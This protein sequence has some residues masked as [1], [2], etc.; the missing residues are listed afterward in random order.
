M[1]TPASIFAALKTRR[2]TSL[3]SSARF[4]MYCSDHPFGQDVPRFAAFTAPGNAGNQRTALN[5]PDRLVVNTTKRIQMSHH[6]DQANEKRYLHSHCRIGAHR[7]ISWSY[8]FV[9]RL[10]RQSL[11]LPTH[12]HPRRRPCTL[13]PVVSGRSPP[14]SGG[15]PAS[16]GR[17]RTPSTPRCSHRHSQAGRRRSHFSRHSRAPVIT[18]R[19]APR[20]TSLSGEVDVI[21]WDR[22]LLGVPNKSGP[23]E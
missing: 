17:R 4:N 7:R 19:P 23:G 2:M 15:R 22:S 9:R 18:G 13:P 11:P 6:K 21:P 1:G 16:C 14:C 5:L 12:R 8:R 20:R 10:R 3:V